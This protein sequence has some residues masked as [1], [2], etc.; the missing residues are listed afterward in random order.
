MTDEELAAI[1]EQ[2]DRAREVMH[3]YPAMSGWVGCYYKDVPELLSDV[4]RLRAREAELREI[5]QA[6][7]GTS[8]LCEDMEGLGS[9]SCPLCSGHEYRRDADGRWEDAPE[10]PIDGKFFHE[11]AC[12]VTK[13]RALL[14]K[15]T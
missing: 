4:E 2:A 13:A 12:P 3:Q 14:D 15:D 9:P 8:I 5:A 7:A 6:V 10:H 1:R 11:P